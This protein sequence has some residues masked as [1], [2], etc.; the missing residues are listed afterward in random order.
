MAIKSC[1]CCVKKVQTELSEDVCDGV[2]SAIP[3]SMIEFI[4]AEV[5]ECITVIPVC[6][7]YDYILPLH[8]YVTIVRSWDIA[9]RN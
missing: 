9:H 3:I 4:S 8:E 1:A 6:I 7:H 2:S 5:L